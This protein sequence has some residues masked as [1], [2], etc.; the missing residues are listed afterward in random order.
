MLWDRLFRLK[1]AGRHPHAHH[2]LHGRGRAALRPAGGHGPRPDRGRGQPARADR[3]ALDTRG[4]RAALRRRTTRTATSTR[5]P[6]WGSGSRSCPTASCVYADDGEAALPT[7]TAEGSTP[8]ACWCAAARPRGRLPPPHGPDA[9][10]LMS[11]PTT[12]HPSPSSASGR[13]TTGERRPLSAPERLGAVMSH[14]VVVYRRTWK[15]SIIGRFLSPLFFLLVDGPRARAPSST[16]ARAGSGG[17]PTSSSSCPASSRS[18]PC[19]WPS[20]SR[21]IPSS[22]T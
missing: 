18:R 13:L 9:G 22:A 14:H 10:R 7:C 12:G 17:S 15:G 19:G 20:G 21:R 11:A 1:R 4:A 3:R 8:V 6:G 16:T 5:S 2:A